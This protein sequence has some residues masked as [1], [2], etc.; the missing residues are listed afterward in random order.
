LADTP[1]WYFLFET[2]PSGNPGCKETEEELS[3]KKTDCKISKI[4]S[5]GLTFEKVLKGG[6]NDVTTILLPLDDASS[7]EPLSTDDVIVPCRSM[8]RSTV[9]PD[10]IFSIQNPKLGKF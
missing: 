8:S 2:I 9:L 6:G 5:E 3:Q 10:G 7:S 4:R 1:K